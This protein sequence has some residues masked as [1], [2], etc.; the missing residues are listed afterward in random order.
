MWTTTPTEITT[1]Q[2]NT[3]QKAPPQGGAYNKTIR[4][5]LS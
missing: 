3:Q 1:K 4:S 5:Q 2:Q